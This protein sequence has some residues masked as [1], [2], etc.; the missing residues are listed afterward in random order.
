MTRSAAIVVEPAV[1]QLGRILERPDIEILSRRVTWS[2]CRKL[3]TTF[4]IADSGLIRINECSLVSGPHPAVI[5][6][7]ALELAWL[8]ECPNIHPAAAGIAAARAAWLFARLDGS[9]SAAAESFERA[10][11]GPSPPSVAGLNRAWA[12]LRAHQPAFAGDLPTTDAQWL[13][14]CWSIIGPVECLL[15]AGGDVRL[16]VDPQTG[17]NAYGCSHRPRPWAIT[18]ASTTASSV[19][20]RAYIAAESARRRI[21]LSALAGRG[22][23][24]LA[25]LIRARSK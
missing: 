13:I 12:R 4:E 14:G 2:V 10:L 1:E 20:Q 17:L 5:V 3:A 18:F 11:S 9:Q 25:Y 7:H 22:N 16:R 15:E 6:R 24:A 23:S 8:L 21:T 19:S